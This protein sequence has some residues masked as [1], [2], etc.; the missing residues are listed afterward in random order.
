MVRPTLVSATVVTELKIYLRRNLNKVLRVRFRKSKP[1]ALMIYRHFVNEACM[2]QCMLFFCVLCNDMVTQS[3]VSVRYHLTRWY[4][5][6][7]LHFRRPKKRE[8]DSIAHTTC[9]SLAAFS[10]SRPPQ[11]S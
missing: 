7:N 2:Y 4:L 1:T 9:Q 6:C 5:F 11:A 8:L 3:H 10:F